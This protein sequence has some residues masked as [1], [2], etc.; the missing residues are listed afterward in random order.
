MNEKN[1][2]LK[3]ALTIAEA[4]EYAC[5]SR[6]IIESW[7]SQGLLPFEELPG[8][9]EGKG[10]Q[11]FRRI[12]RVDL[13]DFLGRHYRCEKQ[14][15]HSNNNGKKIKRPVILLSRAS[16]LEKKHGSP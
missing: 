11:R 2:D 8:T 16:L 6:G 9:G 13:E 15:N 12:R 1:Q 3:R 4:A 10:I 7:L 14:E 5:V